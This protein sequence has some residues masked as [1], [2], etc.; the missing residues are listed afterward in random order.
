VTPPRIEDIKAAIAAY[1]SAGGDDRRTLLPSDAAHLLVA[2]FPLDDV[3][4]GRVV[5]LRKG[6]FDENTARHLL[7]TLVD[8]RFLLKERRRGVPN[9]YRLTLPSPV[10]R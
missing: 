8:A 10:R 5:D 1:N 9:I 7:R 2:M 3:Y 4:Q 6:E